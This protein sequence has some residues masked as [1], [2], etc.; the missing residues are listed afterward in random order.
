MIRKVFVLLVRLHNIS[1]ERRRLVVTATVLQVVIDGGL[2]LLPYWIVRRALR[3]GSTTSSSTGQSA[4]RVIWAIKVTN[5]H[6]PWV[7]CLP[8]AMAAHLLLSHHGHDNT[9]RIGVTRDGQLE[10]HSW[11][12]HRGEPVVGDDVDLEEYTPFPSF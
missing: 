2:R 3:A 10:A 11:V 6:I 8:K 5:R 9:L 7:G 4:E 1:P 12:V